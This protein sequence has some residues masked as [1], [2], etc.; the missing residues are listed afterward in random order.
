MPKSW[1]VVILLIAI[2]VIAGAVLLATWE[3]PA[4]SQQIEKVLPDDRFPN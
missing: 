4:P 2:I 1:I 3:I